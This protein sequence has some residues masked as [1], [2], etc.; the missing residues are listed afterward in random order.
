MWG[1]VLRAS[2]HI[3]ITFVTTNYDRAIELAA[4]S[5][6]IALDDGFEV[7][8]EGET[9]EWTGFGRSKRRAMLVKLRG[10]T[11]WF[12][13]KQTGNPIKLRHPMPL[14]GR[15]VLMFDERELDSALVLPSREKML[16]GAPYPRLSQ[17]FLNAA[18][19][20]DVRC[21]LDRRCVII[22]SEMQ[23]DP[24]SI[25]L[26][27]SLLARKVAT[28]RLKGQQQFHN[29]QAP[30]WCRRCRMHCLH[31]I[32]RLY[33]GHEWAKHPPETGCPR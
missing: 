9:G 5:E 15:S 19:C 17:T 2:E 10:S 3:D 23:L 26:L 8:A 33:S 29:M 27:C 22:I 25:K 11:D 7:F 16:T 24:L 13:D 1:S 18:D 31:Q 4:N 12:A 30:S 32:L 6:G 28:G 21:L 20:C 14:F